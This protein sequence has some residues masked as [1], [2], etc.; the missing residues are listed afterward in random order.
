MKRTVIVDRIISEMCFSIKRGT[1]PACKYA[2]KAW[3][4]KSITSIIVCT[5]SE[6]TSKGFVTTVLVAYKSTRSVNRRFINDLDVPRF[7]SSCPLLRSRSLSP[8]FKSFFEQGAFFLLSSSQKT[9]SDFLL[10][11]PFIH[12]TRLCVVKNTSLVSLSLHTIFTM[13]FS[14]AVVPAF[15]AA[16]SAVTHTSWWARTRV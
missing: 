14:F 1:V 13:K 6:V 11:I 8:S 12:Q 3:R 9:L 16:V 5:D 4:K 2:K 7:C 15:V 10:S